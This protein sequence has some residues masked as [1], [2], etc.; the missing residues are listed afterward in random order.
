[1]MAKDISL[2][3]DLYFSAIFR[4]PQR[5]LVKHLLCDLSKYKTYLPGR[6]INN[7]AENASYK[8][9]K[10]IIQAHQQLNQCLL[11]LMLKGKS[12]SY[13][14]LEICEKFT[15]SRR[16]CSYALLKNTLSLYS[17]S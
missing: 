2:T 3:L 12:L 1:M 13:A 16:C 15:K 11:G 8:C 9:L 17:S 7:A 14:V 4:E 6:A 5:G 10:F